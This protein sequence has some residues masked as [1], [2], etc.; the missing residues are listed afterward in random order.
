[1]TQSHTPET[2]PGYLFNGRKLTTARGLLSAIMRDCGATET[3]MVRADRTIGAFADRR[4]PEI[5]TYTVSP[6]VVG[7]PM[8]VARAALSL[9]KE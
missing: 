5:A 2:F 4:G 6:P 9:A 1:M 7:K 3:T 8:I